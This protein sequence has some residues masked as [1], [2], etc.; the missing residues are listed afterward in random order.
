MLSLLGAGNAEHHNVRS[1]QSEVQILHSVA[2]V[3]TAGQHFVGAVHAADMG[4]T[5]GFGSLG[6]GG[7][8]VAGAHH[9][10][11][12]AVNGANAAQ[13]FPLV[14][15]HHVVIFRDAAQEHQQSGDDMFADGDA[16]CA[17]GVGQD[18][19]GAA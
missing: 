14:L 18:H 7:A 11:Y 12:A 15:V 16:V 2:L 3:E 4:R 19:A 6:K 5:Q 17:G 1:G 10:D 8:D 13:I 9:G